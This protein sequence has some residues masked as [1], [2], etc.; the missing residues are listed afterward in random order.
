VQTGSGWGSI[1]C[2]PL[3][4]EMNSAVSEAFEQL[5]ATIEKEKRRHS[6]R[7]PVRSKEWQGGKRSDGTPSLQ[8]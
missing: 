8:A 2:R 7:I 6:P 1:P 5:G 3:T 4:V